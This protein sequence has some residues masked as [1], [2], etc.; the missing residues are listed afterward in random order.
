MLTLFLLDQGSMLHT[1]GRH[2]GHCCTVH[3]GPLTS[4]KHRGSSISSTRA[5]GSKP[6]QGAHGSARIIYEKAD[7]A[8]VETESRCGAH[9]DYS[10]P[11]SATLSVSG[12]TH[13]AWQRLSFE[14]F[15]NH[16]KAW[17]DMLAML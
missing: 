8:I 17:S 9:K 3:S 16:T 13:Q 14:R 2:T 12:G 10:A 1:C 5:K 15:S 11:A 7:Q 6:R 4:E